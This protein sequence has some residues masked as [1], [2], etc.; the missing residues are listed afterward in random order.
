MPSAPGTRASLRDTPVLELLAARRAAGYEGGSGTDGYKLGL[1]IEGGGMR[2]VL[3]GAMLIALRDAGL[4]AVT[5]G[6]YATSSGAI[7]AAYF[8]AGDAWRALAMYYDFL[9][10]TD[11][12]DPR[13]ALTGQPTVALDTLFEIMDGPLA[14]DWARALT[15][16]RRWG[17]AFGLSR[18]DIPG[19]TVVRDVDDPAELRTVLRLGAWIPLA[20]GP[21]EPWRDGRY[22]DGG[23]LCPAPYQLA[24][25]DGCTHVLQLSTRAPGRPGLRAME[26]YLATRLERITAGAAGVYRRAVLDTRAEL[27]RIGTT[28]A[29]LAAPG[30]PGVVVRRI[31]CP[32]DKPV[33]SRWETDRA[34]LLAAAQLAYDQV[35]EALDGLV[36]AAARRHTPPP[37]L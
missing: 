3:S 21:P 30:T 31:T 10:R 15:A 19:I 4:D 17:F 23:I 8:A 26:R 28:D 12:I 2:G 22:F 16:L 32:G 18:I 20:A 27:N 9:P 6:V 29:V 24:L 36:P 14:L 37:H 1:A 5:D 11:F 25:A 34:R 33:I 35:W 13:R 7:N